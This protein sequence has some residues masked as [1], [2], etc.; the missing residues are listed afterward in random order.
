MEFEVEWWERVGKW[1]VVVNGKR[2]LVDS[3]DEV[4]I[5]TAMRREHPFCTEHSTC[6]C[7]E[8]H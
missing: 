3:I 5:A 2:V 4:S 8:S 7:Q 1:S 6:C